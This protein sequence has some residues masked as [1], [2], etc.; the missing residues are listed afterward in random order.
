MNE[1]LV[2]WWIVATFSVPCPGLDQIKIDKYGADTPM[3]YT[4]CAVNHQESKKIA[5][6]ETFKTK[7]EA[8]TFVKDAPP[9]IKKRMKLIKMDD[10]Q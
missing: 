3:M 4:S 5:K 9:A 2:V 10:E 8:E 1:Y 6:T 7:D